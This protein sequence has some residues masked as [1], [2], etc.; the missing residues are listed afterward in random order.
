MERSGP[1]LERNIFDRDVVWQMRRRA[2]AIHALRINGNLNNPGRRPKTFFAKRRTEVQR[3]IGPARRGA[4]RRCGAPLRILC[5]RRHGGQD[6]QPEYKR[7]SYFHAGKHTT[8]DI[9][10]LSR[11]GRRITLDFQPDRP[12]QLE[13]ITLLNDAG[14]KAVIE[15][16]PAIFEMVLEVKIGGSG[17][18]C[19]GQLREGEVMR[20]DQADGPTV[21]ETADDRFGADGSIV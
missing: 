21:N 4:R 15:S 5:R 10:L 14:M 6:Q 12:H 18:E 19:F 1:R 2:R 17:R 9:E 8:L 3:A 11:I 13:R 7:E 16:H 20:C